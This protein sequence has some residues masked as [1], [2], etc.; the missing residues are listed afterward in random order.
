MMPQPTT[1]ARRVGDQFCNKDGC[2]HGGHADTQPNN[3]PSDRLAANSEPIRAVK[4]VLET[5]TSS[6]NALSENRRTRGSMAP[7]I[8]PVS[9]PNKNRQM[10]AMMVMP[11]MREVLLVSHDDDWDP[12][13]TL[14]MR[15]S[16]WPLPML[17]LLLLLFISAV[18]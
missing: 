2:R 10:E 14:T 12:C 6:W 7:L 15:N 3:H 8:K 16:L 4:T 11:T 18:V 13:V 1:R 9:Y 5:T 17:L